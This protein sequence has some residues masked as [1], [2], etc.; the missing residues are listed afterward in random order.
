[1]SHFRRL[2]RRSSYVV[3][4]SNYEIKFERNFKIWSNFEDFH[5]KKLR[6]IL[7]FENIID[8]LAL[9]S[10]KSL[11]RMFARFGF[12]KNHSIRNMVIWF[13]LFR[14]CKLLANSFSLIYSFAYIKYLVLECVY[15]DQSSTIFYSKKNIFHLNMQ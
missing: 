3:D 15:K 14:S 5:N 1:M 6:V 8:P 13:L 12:R 11:K 4:R 7:L 9:A 2:A 10:R